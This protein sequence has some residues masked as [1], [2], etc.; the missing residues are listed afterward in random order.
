VNPFGP[1]FDPAGKNTPTAGLTTVVLFALYDRWEQADKAATCNRILLAVLEK[2][3]GTESP[4]LV[5]TLA[6]EAKALRTLG[7]VAEA[8]KFDQRVA[9]I[10]AATMNPN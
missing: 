4:I 5:N 9:V 7:R 2:R 1:A 10:R 6:S 3:Y 8:D